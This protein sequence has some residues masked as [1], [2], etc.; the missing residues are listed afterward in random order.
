MN[1]QVAPVTEKALAALELQRKHAEYQ[2]QSSH[3]YNAKVK[4]EHRQVLANAKAIRDRE[5]ALATGEKD[6]EKRKDAQEKWHAEKMKKLTHENVETQ[7]KLDEDFKVF[8]ERQLT[9][10]GPIA[11]AKVTLFDW[12][13]AA[14]RA[15]MAKHVGV[16]SNLKHGFD[17]KHL[18]VIQLPNWKAVHEKVQQILQTGGVSEKV[19]WQV[20]EFA[21][22]AAIETEGMEAFKNTAFDTVDKAKRL[23]KYLDTRSRDATREVRV[24]NE[25][26]RKLQLLFPANQQ[27]LT[28]EL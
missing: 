12:F 16:R 4:A 21:R 23:A 11:R 5:T 26:A 14:L 28:I 17:N 3:D 22:Y 25:A 9:K 19:A 24:Y 27:Q 7:Q 1:K 15:A 2:L 10:L 8:K 13:N 6:L 18:V 20:L